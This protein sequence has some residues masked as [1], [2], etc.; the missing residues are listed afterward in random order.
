MSES[1]CSIR[2]AFT[3]KAI[4]FSIVLG[5]LLS[6]SAICLVFIPGLSWTTLNTSCWLY[7][8]AFAYLY[9]PSFAYPFTSPF[10]YPF[11]YP[12][13]PSLSFPDVSFLHSTT[14]KFSSCLNSGFFSP[15]STHL[16]IPV[17]KFLLSV[18]TLH[19]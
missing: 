5:D 12:F 18:L 9:A 16:S 13:A 14:V 8:R 10:T 17:Q 1:L 19:P 7:V 15:N 11:A 6:T 2:L 4:C 3:K